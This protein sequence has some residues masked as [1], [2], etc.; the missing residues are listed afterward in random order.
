MNRVP[1][2][3]FDE[4]IADWLEGDPSM[5]P[6]E[7]LGTV[8]AAVPSIEQRRASRVPRRY[9]VMNRY[10]LPLAAALIVVIGAAYLLTRPASTIGPVPS[11]TAAPTTIEGTWD[12]SF[13][14]QE[15]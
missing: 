7:V 8:L 6:N 3:T 4:R 14:R 11:P 5:A 2:P 13:S 12:V 10:L 15:M 1:N 9:H